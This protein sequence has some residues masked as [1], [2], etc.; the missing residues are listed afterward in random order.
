M[1]FFFYRLYERKL[2]NYDII[3]KEW[4]DGLGI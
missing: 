2:L 1:I 3:D 4:S